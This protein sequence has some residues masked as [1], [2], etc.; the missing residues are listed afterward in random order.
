MNAP[1]LPQA[2]TQTRTTDDHRTGSPSATGGSVT[3]S[4]STV[5][6]AILASA[7]VIAMGVAFHSLGRAEN[8]V[9]TARIMERETKLMAAD[10]QYIRAY[11]SARGIHVPKDHDEAEEK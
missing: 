3:I 11:L 2:N 7:A 9:E 5:I 10:L 8:A 4:G 6:S 1:A